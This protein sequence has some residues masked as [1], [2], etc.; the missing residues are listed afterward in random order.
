MPFCDAEFCETE[1]FVATCNNNEVVVM[2]TALYGR[3]RLGRCVRTDY[4]YVGCKTDVRG[5]F[6]SICSGRRSC[7]LRLPD[8]ALDDLKECPH[9]FKT[10]LEANFTCLPGTNLFD[11]HICCC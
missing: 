1:D 9:E 3:M 5:H 8:P 4:G 2:E 10:Y 7:H 6:D 11:Y